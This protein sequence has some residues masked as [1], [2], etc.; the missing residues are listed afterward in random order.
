MH[1]SASPHISVMAEEMLEGFSQSRLRT[2]YEGTVGAGGHARAL[3]EKHPEIE[4][5]IACDR[6]P[7]ALAIAAHVLAPWKE[8]VHFVHGNFAD[9]DEHLRFC[10]LR[11]VDGFFLTSE[12]LRCSSTR[13]REGLAL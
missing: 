4:M 8:K 2:F 5:Y 3:L 6:D 13:G 1:P 9:C 12:S 10:Q 11:G 7:A